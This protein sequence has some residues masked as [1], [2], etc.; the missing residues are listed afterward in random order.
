MRLR[1]AQP[2]ERESE[3]GD[4]EI[5]LL[6][7]AREYVEHM[8]RI[9]ELT[10]QRHLVEREEMEAHNKRRELE[11]QLYGFVGA[12]IKTRHVV[13]DGRV[14]AITHGPEDGRVRVFECVAAP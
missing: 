1:R 14:I 8:D 11:A 3:M 10:T 4:R 2:S 5:Q 7:K 9:E 6:R 13:V 12:N